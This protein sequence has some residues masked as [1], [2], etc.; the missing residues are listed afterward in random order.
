MSAVSAEETLER[1]GIA[2][3]EGRLENVLERQKQL[4][5]LHK[6]VRKHFDDIIRAIQQDQKRSTDIAAIELVNV[7]D[8]INA[9]YERVD[10]HDVLAKEQDLKNGGSFASF[11]VPRGAALVVQLSSSPLISTLGPLAAALAAGSPTVILGSSK[12]TATNEILQQIILDSLDR[13]AFHFEKNTDSSAAQAF[14]QQPYATAILPDLQAREMFGPLVV[15]KN[16]SIRLIEPYYGVPAGIIDRSYTG[17]FEQVVGHICRTTPGDS[18][19]NPLRVPRLFFVDESIISAFKIACRS[20]QEGTG[21]DLEDL[22]R[23]YYTGYTPRFSGSRERQRG[24][25]TELAMSENIATITLTSGPE[26]V[27]IPTTSLDNSID[28][29]NKINAGTGSQ[30]LY[31]FAGRKEAL[32]LGSFI[33]TSHV[34]INEIPL[35]SLV[36]TSPRTAQVTPSQGYHVEDFSETKTLTVLASVPTD[37]V[38]KPSNLNEQ[39]VKQHQGGRMSYFEQGLI[40][41]AALGLVT[42]S[43]LTYFSYQGVRTYLER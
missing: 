29:L 16:M 17:P 4:A 41:G 23:K 10:F 3:T 38:K 28:M 14:T 12:L 18:T 20:R 13:E 2:W 6:A 1:I 22:L 5:F 30:A 39:R 34:F 36:A 26:I 42:L 8:T 40:L 24:L 43:S 31:I 15:S 27:L 37:S 9:L 25:N 11:L 19:C 33:T 35:S 7:L 32:Y 21:P